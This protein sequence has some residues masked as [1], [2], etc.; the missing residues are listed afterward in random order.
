MNPDQSHRICQNPLKNQRISNEAWRN[1]ARQKKKPSVELDKSPKSR[2]TRFK[3]NKESQRISKN[4]KE[5]NPTIEIVQ[6]KVDLEES[7]SSRFSR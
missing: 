1:L 3:T 7:K 5:L 4:V 6:W 2:P